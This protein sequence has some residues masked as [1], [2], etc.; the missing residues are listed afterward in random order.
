MSLHIQKTESKH[1]FIKV[2]PKF[3]HEHNLINMNTQYSQY[4][5][6]SIN[7]AVQ[8]KQTKQNPV[9]QLILQLL[10]AS[11]VVSECTIFYFMYAI[12]QA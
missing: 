3:L 4:V 8:H 9:F 7:L 10:S 11:W 2:Q 5:T 1:Y 6:V 12:A